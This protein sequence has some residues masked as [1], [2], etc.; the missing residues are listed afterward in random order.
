MKRTG[1]RVPGTSRYDRRLGLHGSRRA[2]IWAACHLVL[3]LSACDG[4][5]TPAEPDADPPGTNEPPTP[6]PPRPVGTGP[7]NGT[8]TVD[9]GTVSVTTD[10]GAVVTLVVPAGAV[11]SDIDVTLRPLTPEGD[12]WMT[13][14]LEPAGLVFGKSFDLTARLPDSI[15]LTNPQLMIG[16]PAEPI[17]VPTT[18]DTAARTLKT[19]FWFFGVDPAGSGVSAMGRARG[20]STRMAAAAAAFA[21]SGGG[22]N[23]F[24]AGPVTCQQMIAN[25]QQAFNSFLQTHAYRLAIDAALS[26]ANQLLERVCPGAEQWIA[27]AKQIACDR[28][29]VAVQP[30]GSPITTLRQFRD[31]VAPILEWVSVAQG[32]A[33]DCTLNDAYTPAVQDRIQ[34]FLTFLTGRLAGLN[35]NDHVTF[36]DLKEEAKTAAELTGIAETLGAS[37]LADLIDTQAFRAAVDKMR[38]NAYAQCVN[39]GWHYALSRLTQ[40]GFWADRDIIGV[41]APRGPNFPPPLDAFN[42]TDDDIFEDIQYCGTDVRFEA[43]VSS[44]GQSAQEPAGTLGTPGSALSRVSLDAPT[45]G[46]LRVAGKLLGFTC[47]NQ[48]VADNELTVAVEGVDVLTVRRNANNDYIQPPIELDV[49]QVAQAVG[50]VPKE[51]ST[52]ELTIRRRRTQ[53]VEPLWGPEEYTLLEAD[54]VWKNPTLDVAVVLPPNVAP[55]DTIPVDVKVDLVDVLGVA[56]SIANIDVTLNVSGGTP[57][58]PTGVTD[59]TGHFQTFVV[60]DAA[61]SPRLTSTATGAGTVALPTSPAIANVTVQATAQSFEGVTGM[62]ETQTC[63]GHCACTLPRDPWDQPGIVDNSYISGS[64]S[65]ASLTGPQVGYTAISGGATTMGTTTTLPQWSPTV[66]ISAEATDF[67]LIQPLVPVQEIHQWMWVKGVGTAR[68][69]TVGGNCCGTFGDATAELRMGGTLF[70]GLHVAAGG[71]FSGTLGPL[72][73]VTVDEVRKVKVLTGEW[74]EVGMAI[75]GSVRHRGAGATS[76]VSGSLSIQ[77]LDLVDI[78][79]NT[80]P[81]VICSAAGV[82]YGA[83]ATRITG[84]GITV[85]R[86]VRQ[87]RGGIPPR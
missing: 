5:S 39:D 65:L 16:P 48:L 57:V 40:I 50:I 56:N 55:G 33:A 7:V 70:T 37:D 64:T 11:V 81:A 31:E 72:D 27:Q 76:T 78:N 44:G 54:L 66:V 49:E 21:A 25:V 26:I 29:G 23:N 43:L 18:V 12:R 41:P 6:P 8:I 71:S 58:Q 30:V 87:V 36:Q 61:P 51:G 24:S 42:F 45:R 68:A 19:Q 3:V 52:S 73:E 60:V 14:A 28:Y 34:A 62:A 22:S 17:Y 2:C 69:E 46:T 13:V 53:C 32:L 74:W 9:G 80:I 83:A 10:E 84:T 15:A 63:T 20:W 77:V 82:D 1:F 75:N 59:A 4:G 47:W 86:P 79:D 38:A 85:S 35:A 67:V